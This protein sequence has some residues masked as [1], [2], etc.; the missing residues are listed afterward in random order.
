MGL[1]LVSR[2]KAATYHISNNDFLSHQYII[3]IE[4]AIERLYYIKENPLH[5]IIG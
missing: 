3:Y 4:V 2:I 5:P 1:N